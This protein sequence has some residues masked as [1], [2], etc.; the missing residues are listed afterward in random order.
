M[1]AGVQFVPA[2]TP[3]EVMKLLEIGNQRRTTEST[4]SNYV[5]SRSHAVLQI[6]VETRPKAIEYRNQIR[7]GKLNMIDLMISKICIV[8]DKALKDDSDTLYI[9]KEVSKNPNEF[10]RQVLD[11]LYFTLFLEEYDKSDDTAIKN[12]KMA[13]Q[14]ICCFAKQIKDRFKISVDWE[15]K[16][17][18]YVYIFMFRIERIFAMLYH[19]ILF[20]M[21]VKIV[22]VYSQEHIPGQ[23][24]ELVRTEI[25]MEISGLEEKIL[26][27]N[28]YFNGHFSN[29]LIK[30]NEIFKTF[31]RPEFEKGILEIE[32]DKAI[33]F[34]L[35]DN[36]KYYFVLKDVQLKEPIYLP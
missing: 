22:N 34:Y 27:E 32:S 33:L 23:Q 17:T 35:E 6:Y 36:K 28:V 18:I 1:V 13:Y 21:I 16:Y 31:L 29:Q 3:G 11:H 15:V 4:R 26:L 8:Y 12:L 7:M 19:R 9:P 30:R 2:K 25:G 20:C 14:C 10:I 24:N 5:S